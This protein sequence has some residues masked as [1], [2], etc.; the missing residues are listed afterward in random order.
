MMRIRR[1][2]YFSLRLGLVCLL[3]ILPRLQGAEQ[4]KRGRE[5]FRKSCVECHGRSGQGVKGKYDEALYGDWTLEKLSRYI[6]KNMPEDAP[7]KCVGAD[8]DAVGRYIYD[9]FYSREAR[10]RNDP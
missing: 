9:A 5:I 1:K 3:F 6:D 2:Q 8:A 4:H 10:L 7:E